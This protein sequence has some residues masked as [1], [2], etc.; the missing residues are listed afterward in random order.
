MAS[1]S[2]TENK[3]HYDLCTDAASAFDTDEKY[4]K[5][6]VLYPLF[7][8]R[9]NALL[10]SEPYNS[11]LHWRKE[12]FTLHDL[13]KEINYTPT[14]RRQNFNKRFTNQPQKVAENTMNLC[15]DLMVDMLRNS[16]I[17]TEQRGNIS[18]VLSLCAAPGGFCVPL[19]DQL[20]HCR[21]LAYSL[22]TEVG[23]LEMLYE[24]ERLT[25]VSKDVMKL[26][27]TEIEDQMQEI[28]LFKTKFGLI[29]VDGAWAEVVGN[30][31]KDSTDFKGSFRILFG[32]T[33][34]LKLKELLL[35]LESLEQN[36]VAVIRV[37]I[38]YYGLFGTMILIILNIVFR[39]VEF[40]RSTYEQSHNQWSSQ[41]AYV[42][43]H[44]FVIGELEKGKSMVSQWLESCQAGKP[45]EEFGKL[46]NEVTESS[47]ANCIKQQ[48]Q[49]FGE[50]AEDFRRNHEQLRRENGDQS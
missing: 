20:P 17:L 2:R 35:M 39:N 45:T 31:D 50:L 49:Y 16:K 34:A 23:G 7:L 36:G 10:P 43:C 41:F 46:F 48:E 1:S 15:R 12:Y 40:F 18:L 5:S 28:D 22:P 9:K 8:S 37:S 3:D 29:C 14:S 27:S 33:V 47:I 32:K 24:D 6:T 42:I 25:F 4:F 11:F 44:E 21:V 30:R 19:L 13:I 26:N 38:K